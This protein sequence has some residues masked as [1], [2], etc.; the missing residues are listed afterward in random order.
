MD[1]IHSYGSKIKPWHKEK[2]IIVSRNGYIKP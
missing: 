2:P 1:T